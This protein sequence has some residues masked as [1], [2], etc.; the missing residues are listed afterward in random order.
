MKL[1]LGT[2]VGRAVAGCRTLSQMLTLGCFS[3]SVGAPP[4]GARLGLWMVLS[5]EWA[6]PSLEHALGPLDP[7]SAP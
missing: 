6:E 2:R 7:H 4:S 5:G 1:G 3:G